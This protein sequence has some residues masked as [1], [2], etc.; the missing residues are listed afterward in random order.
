MIATGGGGKFASGCHEEQTASRSRSRE[1]KK[2]GSFRNAS[3]YSF[4]YTDI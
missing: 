2:R 1:R 4:I 3:I